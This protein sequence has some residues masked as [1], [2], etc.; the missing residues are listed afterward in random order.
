MGGM[1][2][3]PELSIATGVPL[4][5]ESTRDPY[6]DWFAEYSRIKSDIDKPV[7]TGELRIL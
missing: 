2:I 6:Y 4:S 3:C 5:A 1:M 7:C